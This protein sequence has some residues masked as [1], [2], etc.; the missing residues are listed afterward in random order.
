MTDLMA[1]MTRLAFDE[2]NYDE[3]DK[4]YHPD[5]MYVRELEM[6][7]YVEMK[8]H[9][10]EDFGTGRQRSTNRAT[11]FEDELTVVFDHDITPFDENGRQAGEGHRVRLVTLKQEGSWAQ[12]DDSKKYTGAPCSNLCESESRCADEPMRERR[13]E[14]TQPMG[15]Q[16][17]WHRRVSY[18][19]TCERNR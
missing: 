15:K 7:D 4:Y 3:L 18:G 6:L 9:V 2:K 11:L 17:R 14:K 12:I 8:R 13:A 19:M 10:V 1:T 16:A 5:F